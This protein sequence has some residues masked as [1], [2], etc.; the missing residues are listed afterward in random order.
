MGV[1]D[2][3]IK[4]IEQQQPGIGLPCRGPKMCL[5][6]AESTQFAGQF[7]GHTEILQVIFAV[8]DEEVACE[9]A[10]R[11]EVQVGAL[12]LQPAGPLPGVVEEFVL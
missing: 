10:G 4:A 12:S 5:E 9:F 1:P 6:E 3:L 7:E 11:C 8:V 2:M